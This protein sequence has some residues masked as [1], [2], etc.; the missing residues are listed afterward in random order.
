MRRREFIA[1]LASAAAS[2]FD[3]SAQKTVPVIGFLNGQSPNGYAPFAVAFREGLRVSG[4]VEGQNVAIE[5]RWA[6]GHADRL[7]MLA[8][9]LIR[10][11]ITVIT[12]SGG[13]AA[14][15]AAK[16]ATT[17][18]PI[19]F[20]SGDDPVAAGLVTSLNRPDSNL[21]GVSW[22]AVETV[23]KRLALLHELVPAA[24]TIAL[25]VDPNSPESASQPATATEAA[26]Q[27]GLGLI[28]LNASTAEEIDAAFISLQQQGVGALDTASGAFFV[29]RRAQIIALAAKHAIP[30]IYSGRDSPADGGLMSYGNSLLD[31]Y[32]RN[33]IY[34]G[35]ILKGDKP[36]DLPVDRSTK[37]E[38]VINLKTAKTLG[39]EVSASLLARADE[40]IE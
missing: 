18:L 16:A 39:L 10:G 22:F 37:F 26:H 6:E 8:T 5:Y 12:T 29:N 36:G 13:N 7:P 21:T 23:A 35:R 40:V 24:T 19:V 1:G 25:L 11:Q 4:F 38:L 17:T 27:L 2:P 33:A 15:L 34:V 31:A 14:A 20:N 28:V 9:E 32:R 3:A 30:C